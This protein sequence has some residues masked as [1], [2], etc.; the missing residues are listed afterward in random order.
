MKKLHILLYIILAVGSVNS[1][2][3]LPANAFAYGEGWLCHAGHK[4]VGNKCIG[5]SIPANA[6]AYG[7]GWACHVGYKKTGNKCQEMTYAEKQ[8]QL[9]QI[10]IARYTNES[11]EDMTGKYC[12][13]EGARTSGG[14][15]V[16]GECYLYSDRY[17]DLEGARTSTG[18]SVTGECYR[19]SD[20]YGELEG[21]RTSGGESVTGE[22]YIYNQ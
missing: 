14:Q 21:A 3:A 15:S 22:C 18:E 7:E 20:K 12:E 8:K 5:V 13:L 19:Y 11:T 4:K 10:A 6:F 17:G 16:S 2:F 9:E 1:V